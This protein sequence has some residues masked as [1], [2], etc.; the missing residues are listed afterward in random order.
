MAVCF[1]AVSAVSLGLVFPSA[2]YAEE[3]WSKDYYRAVDTS[4]EL[5]EEEKLSLDQRCI[6]FMEASHADL[7]LLAVTSDVYEGATL[8]ELADGYY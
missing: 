6:E 1:A 2:V 3:M 8:T 4:G 5:S 7:S